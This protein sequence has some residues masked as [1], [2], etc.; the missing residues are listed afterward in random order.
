MGQAC[1]L[2]K[3]LA[4]QTNYSNYHCVVTYVRVSGK[5]FHLVSAFHKY[6]WRKLKDD[7]HNYNYM[8]VYMHAYMHTYIHT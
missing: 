6:V 7:R 3:R 1:M 2:R 8:D 4:S 5:G